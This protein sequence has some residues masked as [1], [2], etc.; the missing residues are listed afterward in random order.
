MTSSTSGGHVWP[1]GPHL[2]SEVMSGLRGHVW[3]Q[4]PCM[5]SGAMS[6]LTAHNAGFTENLQFEA[7]F[8][9]YSS[10]IPAT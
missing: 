5:A 1:Q 10:L 6:G 2:A 4:R 7:D 3:P 8:L 9:L